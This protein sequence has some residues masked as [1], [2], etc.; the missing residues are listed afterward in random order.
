MSPKE[1]REKRAALHSQM[2]A[3]MAK[4]TAEKRVPTTE[5]NSDFDRFE[6]EFNDLGA[7]L[8]RV[9]RLDNSNREL[10]ALQPVVLDPIGRPVSSETSAAT[11]SEEYSKAFYKMLRKGP[12]GLSGSEQSALNAGFDPQAAL[13]PAT[14]ST[15]GYTVP[16]GFEDVLVE[17]RKWYGGIDQ[18]S[19][20]ITT[21]TGAPLPWPTANDTVNIGE[22]IGVNTQ[23]SM[24]QPSF[25][26]VMFNGYIFSSKIVL[27]PITLMQDSAFP[28]DTWLPRQLG[29]RIAR[30]QNTKFTVGVGGGTEPTGIITAAAA[31]GNVVQMT[32]G[33]VA[34][35]SADNFTDL[36]TAVDKAYRPGAKYMLNDKTL[37]LVKKLKDSS[38]RSLWLSGLASSLQGGY[39]ATING[40]EYVINNDMPVPGASNYI[41]AFG[42]PTAFKI[43]RVKGYV[44]MRLTERY[45]DYLQV[46]FL[47]AER[48]DS[49]LIDA[50]THPVA[51]LQNSAT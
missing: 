2:T 6:S 16:Q 14:G 26:Q 3:V 1:I 34:T 42:D 17:A 48:A 9:E 37:Q 8:Q 33:N 20:T 51:L 30:I 29:V 25:G 47:A 13:S 4:P 10:N 22:I 27:V 32:T 40:Y 39:P 35:I 19:E 7:H 23:L 5:E 15:G 38:G 46:G 28:L 36:E 45:A 24:A 49:N 12:A 21:D 43:R 41:V 18:F 11:H 44:T 31:A 50:G